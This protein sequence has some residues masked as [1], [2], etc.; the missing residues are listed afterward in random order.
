MT[1]KGSIFK[2][3]S[4]WGS[5]PGGSGRGGN[6]SGSRR[7]P[8]NLDDVIKNFQNLINKFLCHKSPCR[9]PSCTSCCFW[10]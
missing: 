6:G 8:P 7:E 3:Q 4:P 5:T 9:R 1:S 2:N 10:L